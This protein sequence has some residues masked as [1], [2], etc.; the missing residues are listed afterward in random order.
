VGTLVKRT[1]RYVALGRLESGKAE[2]AAEGFAE[3]LNRFDAAM[4]LSMTYDQGRE[5]ARHQDL[6]ARTSVKV[7]F[8]H[9]HSPWGAPPQREYQRLVEPI[10]AQRRRPQ[11]LLAAATRRHRRKPQCT[12]KKVARLES[13]RRTL[14]AR[15]SLRLQKTRGNSKRNQ[16]CCT[17][18]LKAPY[19]CLAAQAGY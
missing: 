17:W 1:T 12:T 11:R 3:I 13:T 10:P 5:M 16:P 18:N 14:S 7:Y 4:R 19:S 6:T 9:P 8:A 2:T 15:G